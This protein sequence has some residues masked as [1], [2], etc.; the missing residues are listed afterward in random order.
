MM[1]QL[2]HGHEYST[3]E[4]L[5]HTHEYAISWL[6]LR[7][8]WICFQK[9]INKCSIKE[10]KVGYQVKLLIS[11]L[12]QLF[13]SKS[14]HALIVS[15]ATNYKL[16]QTNILQFTSSVAITIHSRAVYLLR[17]HIYPS[18]KTSRTDQFAQDETITSGTTPQVYYTTSFNCFRKHKTTP[19]ISK[20]Q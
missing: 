2:Q 16:S 8:H 10:Q 1:C 6:C 5:L 20:R 3:H 4:M 12:T 17:S 18:N 14:N 15:T 9:C 7:S 19:I 13:S 11:T